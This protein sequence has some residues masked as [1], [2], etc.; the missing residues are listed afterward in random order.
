VLKQPGSIDFSL[1]KQ[2]AR[3]K[4]QGN[5]RLEEA[6]TAM[7]QNQAILVQTQASFVAG[8]AE[9]NSRMAETDRINSERFARIEAILLEHSRILRALPEAVREKI[10]FKAPDKA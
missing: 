6:M 5:G 1:R 9:T 7:L 3:S 10:G 2:M 8:L 4:D